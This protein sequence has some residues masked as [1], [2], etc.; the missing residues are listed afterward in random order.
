MKTGRHGWFFTGM[1][2]AVVA[3]VAAGFA[4]TYY[5]K[6]LVT[7][8]ALPPLIHLHGALFT[9]W[10]LLFLAQTSLVAAKRTDLHKRLGIGGLVILYLVWLPVFGRGRPRLPRTATIHR[11]PAIF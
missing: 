10:V 2:L 9:A 5:L 4:P 8:P 1:A 3:T 11:I 7:S 6:P